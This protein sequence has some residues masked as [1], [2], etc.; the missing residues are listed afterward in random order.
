MNPYEYLPALPSSGLQAPGASVNPES[1]T[2]FPLAQSPRRAAEVTVSSEPRI[3]V[4][5]EKKKKSV[6]QVHPGA[7]VWGSARLP[8]RMLPRVHKLVI[9]SR[10]LDVA[11]EG[12]AEPPAC[13]R[14]GPGISGTR[15]CH[16]CCKRRREWN[17][18]PPP[19]PRPGITPGLSGLD[20]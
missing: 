17:P 16:Y 20:V 9:T 10:K 4:R 12:P 1:R 11:P 3:R 6:F 18:H 5:F 7:A 2:G 14:G 19:P 15:T 8:L 13:L